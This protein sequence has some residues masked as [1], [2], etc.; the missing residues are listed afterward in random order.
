MRVAS[1]LRQQFRNLISIGMAVG[2]LFSG[3]A[4]AAGYP[5]RPITLIVPYA[6]GTNAD[7]LAREVAPR[8]GARLGQP[9]VVVNKPGAGAII[10]TQSVAQ[11]APDGYTLLFGA[12]QTAINPSLYKKL[13][14]DTMKALRPVVRVSNQPMV[15]VIDKSMPARTVSEFVAYAKKHPDKLNYADTGT[16]NSVHLAGAFFTSESSVRIQRVSFNS[17]GD[18]MSGMMRGDINLLFYP[19]QAVAGQISAGSLRALATTGD[20]RAAFLPNL[21]TMVE[22]GYKGFV[23]P[24]WQGIFVPAKTPESIVDALYHS[25]ADAL[26]DPKVQEKFLKTG[27]EVR[28]ESPQQFEKFFQEQVNKYRGLVKMTG[29][30]VN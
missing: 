4:R 7:M 2:I 24:A 6:A 15:M 25:V 5:S 16:G 18:L 13:P 23:L 9:I 22:L 12:T 19:Y 17:F 26:K 28:V 20:K 30:T 10:G 14:Y 27:T 3:A 29:A 21:P 1:T 8:M 11:S